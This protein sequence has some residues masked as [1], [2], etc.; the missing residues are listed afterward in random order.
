MSSEDTGVDE[1]QVQSL[2]KKHKDVT[3]ELKNYANVIQQ[4]KQQVYD[5]LYVWHWIKYIMNSKLFAL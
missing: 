3:D 1:A 5:F 4:L 2:L